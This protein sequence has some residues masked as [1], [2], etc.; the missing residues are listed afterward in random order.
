MLPS[1]GHGVLPWLD[2]GYVIRNTLKKA[3]A[4]S[5]PPIFIG[6]TPRR[7]PSYLLLILLICF[8]FIFYL[9]RC[10]LLN[11]LSI[12]S[13]AS[14]PFVS[15]CHRTTMGTAAIFVQ[16]SLVCIAWCRNVPSLA[17]VDTDSFWRTGVEYHG[18]ISCSH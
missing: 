4:K 3:C 18:A 10:T 1:R 17:L 11:F 15:W 13:Q 6:I 8:L 7:Y 14:L 12:S 2:F 16:I 9:A 5:A